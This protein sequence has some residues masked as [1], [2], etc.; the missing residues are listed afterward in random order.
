MRVQNFVSNDCGLHMI[1]NPLTSERAS[2]VKV[3]LTLSCCSLR[4]NAGSVT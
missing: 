2:D 3:A 1:I 4:D